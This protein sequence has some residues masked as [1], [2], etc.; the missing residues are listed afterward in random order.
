MLKGKKIIVAIT[1]SIAAYK[2]PFLVRLLI[3]DGAQVKVLMTPSACDFV[4]PL[5]LSTLSQSPVYIKPFNESDGSWTSHI[6]LGS[7]ADVMLFAPLSANTMAKMATGI[8]DNLLTAVYLAARCPVFFA[9][10]MD[11]DMYNHPSTQANIKRLQSFGNILINPREGELAS[12]LSGCGRL[13]EPENIL[14]V[15]HR[16][17][18]NKASLAGKKVLVTSGPTIEPIDPVRFISNHSSG[19]MGNSIAVEAAQRGAEVALISGPVHDLPV[20]P[21]IQTIK[22]S[23]A[24]EMLEETVSRFGQ[25]DIAIMAAAVSDYTPVNVSDEKIKKSAGEGLTLQLTQTKDILA[26]LG[27]IKKGGQVLVGFA[28][29]TENEIENAVRKLHTK[30]LDCIVL[31]SMKDKGAGFSHETNRISI[32]SGKNQVCTYDLKPKTAVASDILD[33]ITEHFLKV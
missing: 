12:G 26:E 17:F 33:Y 27:K 21:N 15:L 30:N 20:H 18:A 14:K 28:L 2:I 11:V 1:G 13:E 31:N 25:A 4:T 3:R 8:T 23:K 9:P 6:E 7:W 22:V 19:L 10:A 32:I 16:F 29:E 24:G 5:T